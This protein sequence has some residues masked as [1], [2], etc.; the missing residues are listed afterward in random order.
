MAGI[1]SLFNFPTSASQPS[2]SP[3]PTSPSVLVGIGGLN[4]PTR[5]NINSQFLSL[6]QLLGGALAVAESSSTDKSDVQ[7]IQYAVSQL[8]PLIDIAALLAGKPVPANLDTH[9]IQTLN[10]VFTAV[11]D[12]Q[13]LLNLLNTP[14]TP[15]TGANIQVS[16]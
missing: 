12:I 6:L 4:I 10:S 14:N 3:T 11:N 15:M 1:L 7:K 16:S 13:T 2:V 9:V 5:T 8:M